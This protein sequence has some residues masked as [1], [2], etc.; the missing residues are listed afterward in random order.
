LIYDL[1]FTRR[2]TLRLPNSTL[3]KLNDKQVIHRPEL[4]RRFSP[5]LQPQV[6]SISAISLTAAW[7]HQ[8]IVY[9]Q[10]HPENGFVAFLFDDRSLFTKSACDF[11][12]HTAR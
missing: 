3:N 12:W 7:F 2:L 5:T 10:F 9:E 1:R 6:S 4:P 8:L 11:A